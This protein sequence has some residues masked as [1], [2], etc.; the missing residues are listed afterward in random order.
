METENI[1]DWTLTEIAYRLPGG[2]W[3]RTT[4]KTK[5]S[6]TKRIAALVED[7]AEI[8]LSPVGVK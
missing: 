3:K 1:N 6:Y 7:G 5:K 2:T 8:R 4:P